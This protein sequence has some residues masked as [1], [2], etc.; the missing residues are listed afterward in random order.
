MKL[1]IKQKMFSFKSRFTIKDQYKNDQFFVEGE[2]FSLGHKLHV[3]DENEQEIALVKQKLLSF[4]PK[5]E[6]YLDNKLVTTIDQELT[7]IKHKHTLRGLQWQVAGDIFHHEYQITERNKTI[8]TISKVWFSMS[9]SYEIDICETK[10]T[11]LVVAIVLAIDC[12]HS[13][14]YSTTPSA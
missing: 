11:E 5:Y 2:I 10:N 7:L 1:Y 13:D 12:V 4:L 9:D 3:F 6:V 8:A 14:I